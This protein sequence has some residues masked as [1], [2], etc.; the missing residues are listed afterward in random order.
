MCC[1]WPSCGSGFA[2]AASGLRSGSMFPAVGGP[3]LPDEATDGDDRIGEV[4]VGVD[5]ACAA[6]V[7]AL[8]PVEAVVPGVGALEVPTTAGLHR[9]LL[10][11]V[12]DLAVLICNSRRVGDDC[13]V[14]AE[15]ISTGA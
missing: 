4:E 10:A 12:R 13:V 1:S 7:A 2:A 15:S 9:H 8:E 3:G 11:L 6:F 14:R 5:H